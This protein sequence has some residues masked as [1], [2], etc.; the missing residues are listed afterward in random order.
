MARH[1]CWTAPVSQQ[2]PPPQWGRG[3]CTGTQG[4]PESSPVIHQGSQ[5]RGQEDQIQR[6]ELISTHR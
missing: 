2:S 4:E 5:S 6:E 3:Q 1:T